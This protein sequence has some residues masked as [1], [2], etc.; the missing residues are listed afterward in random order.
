MVPKARQTSP[1][2]RRAAGAVALSTLCFAA[3]YAAPPE[4]PVPGEQAAE[5]A[6]RP[7][8]DRRR[9]LAA[10][11]G[12]AAGRPDARV[13][14]AEDVAQGPL[15]TIAADPR[16]RRGSVVLV[17]P[18]G[19]VLG[20]HALEA[21]LTGALAAA[22]FDSYTVQA[23]LPPAG[24]RA[25]R[26]GDAE[27]TRL[28]RARVAAACRA[29]AHADQPVFFVAVGTD[30][31]LALPALDAVGAGPKMLKLAALV[32]IDAVPGGPVSASDTAEGSEPASFAEALAARAVPL[33]LVT[34]SG[35]P[36]APEFAVARAL[37]V[38]QASPRTVSLPE[39]GPR[40]S[41]LE[42]GL[43]QRVLGFFHHVLAPRDGASGRAASA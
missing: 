24:R 37:A 29:V 34:T 18:A 36:R 17:G 1:L 5:S 32:G 4:P 30:M 15:L 23:P 12:L 7:I 3:S 21:A 6:T 9:E 40:R 42:T 33:M 28:L 43:V 16:H 25:A 19:F 22:G 20:E 10:A 26:S 27:W 39:L 11:R 41:G 38:R 31:S 14:G 13:L 35:A 8:L 2:Y